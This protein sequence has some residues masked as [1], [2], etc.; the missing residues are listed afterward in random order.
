MAYDLRDFVGDLK[1]A[2]ELVEIND[3]V[4]WNY[5]ISAYE[6]ISG[7][8]AGPA[9]LF[10]N[11]KGIPKGARALVGHF[12]GSFR[13]PHRR[14]AMCLGIPPDLDRATFYNMASKAMGTMLKPVEVATGECKEVIKMGAELN[15]MEL[16]F[17]YHAIGDGGKYIFSNA[18]T[19]KDPDSDWMNT[20]NYAIEVFSRNRLV[21]T[22]Y[23]HTNFVALYTNKYQA[24]GKAMPV[25]VILGGD[26][27][28]TMAAGSI[29]PPGV[30]EYDVAGGLRQ[31]PMEMVKAETSDL[32][33]PANA[34][35][36]IEGEIRPYE[37]LP[38]GPKTEVFGF[39][40]GPRQPFYAIRVHCITHRRNPIVPDIHTSLGCGT[41][42]LNETLIPLGYLAQ[43]KMFQIL[44]LKF[45]SGPTPIKTGATIYNAVRKKRY[46]EDYPGFME[47][48][49]DRQNGLPGMGGAWGSNLFMDDDVNILDY[50][51]AVEAQATQTNPVRDIIRTR[52]MFPSPTLFCSWMEEEDR[53]KFMGPGTILSDKLNTDATTKEEPPLGVRRMQFETL[54]PEKLQKWVIDNW[55]RL[56]FEEEARWNNTWL[57]ADF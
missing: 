40:T 23:A 49:F 45:G 52:K 12:A 56:G 8:F 27:A 26:P 55:Q 33:V 38:E 36:V 5:E 14:I 29:L 48:L 21:I 54:Y 15:L 7:R 51:E 46:P 43:I 25:A 24:R 10:N 35:V 4:D 34:E 44:P 6:V 16:P 13:R 37:R 31:S 41:H 57:K 17:T 11:I 30:S 1:K 47:D 50:G 32:L 53:E 20:G 22:P 9:F 42:C 39:S 28:V 2:G 18:V 19:I 3:E